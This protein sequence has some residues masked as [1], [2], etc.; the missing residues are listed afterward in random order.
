MKYFEKVTNY[1]VDI[2]KLKQTYADVIEK[3]IEWSRAALTQ[4]VIDNIEA[5]LEREIDHQALKNIG[6][7]DGLIL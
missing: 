4:P 5:Q 1:S 6:K 3:L 7:I 2:E